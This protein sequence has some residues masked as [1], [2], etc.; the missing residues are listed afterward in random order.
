MSLPWF[1]GMCVAL[2]LFSI[3][4]ATRAQRNGV[5]V[6][7]V[8]GHSHIRIRPSPLQATAP[9]FV[10][11]INPPA[12][13]DVLPGG[14][15]AY[16]ITVDSINGFTGTIEFH[17]S[18]LPLGAAATFVP[19]TLVGS[20]TVKV[21]ISTSNETPRGKYLILVSGTSMGIT[22]TGGV[23]LN[24]GEPQD[25]KDFSGTVTPVFQTVVPGGTT[26]FQIAI[27]P[28]SGFTQ[29]V[30]LGISGLPTGATASFNP[31]VIAGGNGSAVLTVSMPGSTPTGTYRLPIEATGGEKTHSNTVAVN[32]GPPGMDFTDF[33]GSVTPLS[34]T[35][36]PGG[37]AAYTV[38]I[39]P[40]Y[41]TGCI[42]LQTLNTPPASSA[43]YDRTTPICAAPAKT[44]LTVTTTPQTPPGEYT[45]TIEGFS[46][47]GF[48][49]SSNILLTVTTTP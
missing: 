28:I 21:V 49:H 14:M 45:I 39:E 22:H 23:T 20:G 3:G 27:F 33:T 31:T 15:A 46:S 12:Y 13:Q 6:A 25:F 1:R 11:S 43:V 37:I 35:V 7:P 24:V 34:Q 40:L 4:T 10:G 36:R 42:T 47:G 18:G 26:T 32:V 5:P 16:T 19:N 38:E 30:S 9:D 2:L 17:A 48:V 44:I 8:D 29:D 41:G